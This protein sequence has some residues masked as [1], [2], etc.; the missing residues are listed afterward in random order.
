VK[1]AK[2]GYWPKLSVFAETGTNYS[3]AND[4]YGFSDQIFDNNLNA[5]IG[6]SLT[7]PIFDKGVTKNNVASAKVKLKNQQLE[8]EK[9]DHQV[10]LEVQQ[11]I[12]DYY[13]AS[14]QINVTESQ[15][16]YSRAALKSVEERYNVNA[17][18]M[19][20]LIQTR[21]QYHQSLY[22]LVEAKFNLFIRGIA[23]S[24]YQGDRDRMI[25]LLKIEK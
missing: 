1:A 24:F 21:A 6:M 22:D 10:R 23:V 13:T 9:L 12:E 11:A 20:E 8:L 16:E 2:S 25:S 17:A 5:T 4:F 15:E 3:N 7:I 18:T 14:K 19:A